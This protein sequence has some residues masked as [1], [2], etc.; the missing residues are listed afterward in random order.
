MLTMMHQSGAN[1][2]GG[3]EVEMENKSMD[4]DVDG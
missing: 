1:S 2:D 3:Q 4:L